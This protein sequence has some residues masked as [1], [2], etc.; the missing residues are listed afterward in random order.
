MQI[1][2]EEIHIFVDVVYELLKMGIQFTSKQNANG[3]WC[4]T[5]TGGY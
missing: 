5:L 1:E 3:K 4:I 2:V